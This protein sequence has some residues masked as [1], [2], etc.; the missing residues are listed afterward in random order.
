MV[1][2]FEESVASG[3]FP[4]NGGIPQAVKDDFAFYSIAGQLE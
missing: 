2:Y 4:S 1:P 3:A